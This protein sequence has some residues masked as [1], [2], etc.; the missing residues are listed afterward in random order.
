MRII[1]CFKQFKVR[2]TYQSNYKKITRWVGYHNK[3]I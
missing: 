1:I 3:T 2:L